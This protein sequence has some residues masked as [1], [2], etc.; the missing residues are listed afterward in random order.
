[1]I[2]QFGRLKESIDNLKD[3][4]LFPVQKSNSY[5]KSFNDFQEELKRHRL[6]L[7]TYSQFLDLTSDIWNKIAIPM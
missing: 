4:F 5:G 1:M 3:V 6:L 2:F 7:V